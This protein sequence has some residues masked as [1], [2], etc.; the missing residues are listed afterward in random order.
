LFVVFINDLPSTVSSSV[1]IF[2]DDT[3]VYQRS[4]IAGATAEIQSDI[5]KLQQWSDDWLLR[6]HPQKC[7]VLK[8]GAKNSEANY[9]MKSKDANGDD[10]ILKLAESEA[11]KDLGVMIDN[12]LSFKQHVSQ[13]TSKA[14]RTVGIIRRSFTCLTEQTFV[15]LYK[16]LVRPTLEYGHSVYNPQSKQLCCEL[17]DV[18]RRATKLLAS[19][20]DKPY[21]ERLRTLRLPSLEHRRSRGDMIEVYKYLHGMYCTQRP[22]FEHPPAN[23]GLRGSTL[24]LQKNRFRLNIRGHFFTNRVTTSWNSLPQSVVD[25]PSVNAFK[26]R[27]DKH[28]E[29]LPTLYDPTCYH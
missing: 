9:Y 25:A 23:H 15:T 5:D 17:E 27:L 21:E 19:L 12:K 24:K 18:Q 26:N 14:N 16:S 20:K 10:C 1:K 2:A 7:R 13:A 6:F 29:S 3:K 11:E 28:W 8:L 22:R 4:D